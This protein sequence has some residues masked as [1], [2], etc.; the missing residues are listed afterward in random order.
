MRT[1]YKT[2]ITSCFILWVLAAQS[3][4]IK[5]DSLHYEVLMN[6]KMLQDINL[7][8]NFV[9]SIDVTTDSLILLSSSNQFYVLGWGGMIPLGERIFGSISSFNLTPDKFLMVISEN[10]ICKID[11]TGTLIR[12]I[13]LPNYGMGLSP[14]KNVMFVFDREKNLQKNSVYL[15]VRGGKYAKLFDVTTP[16]NSVFDMKDSLLFASKNGLFSFDYQSKEVKTIAYIN[17]GREIKSVTADTSTKQIFF[18]TDSVVYALENSKPVIL[19]N[20]FGGILKF[21]SGGLIVFNP[22]QKFLIRI[23]GLENTLA[24]I[25]KKSIVKKK[26]DVLLTNES[27]IKMVNDKIPEEQ[28]IKA[29][30][31]SNAN[32]KLDVN[33]VI[34][35]SK[36][37]VS[38]AVIEAMGKAMDNN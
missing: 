5:N 27:I 35:L 34:N 11:S 23:L 38:S 17:Q 37:N 9:N 13:K 19:T 33:S 20:K 6:S 12:Q 10:Y 2:I 29:I 8:V 28:I 14:G 36:Q 30:N 25:T 22:T 24:P 3:L 21:Y 32:F 1:F 4:T 26:S 16:V 31:N 18:S 7:N 15:I